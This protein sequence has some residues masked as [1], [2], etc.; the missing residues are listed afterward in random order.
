MDQSAT[1]RR[2][3]RDDGVPI[4]ALLTDEIERG[5]AH[6]GTEP[7]T[8][9]TVLDRLERDHETY[10][11]LVAEDR[12]GAFLGFASASAWNP[13][14][15]YAWCAEVSVYLTPRACG[16]GIGRALYGRLFA[17]LE[18]QGYRSIVAAASM[19]NDASDRLHRSMGMRVA[20]EHERIGRKFGRWIDVR[21]YQKLVGDPGAEPGAIAPVGETIARLRDRGGGP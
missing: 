5:V 15:A 14:G 6:F 8:E 16:R 2:A 4:A 9:G 7:E 11:W 17:I 3:R 18:A 10:P 1:I 12:D 13:R 21:Y 19:P 20:G